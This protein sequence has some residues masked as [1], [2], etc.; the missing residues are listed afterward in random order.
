MRAT[1]DI[2]SSERDK[3]EEETLAVVNKH[4]AHLRYCGCAAATAKGLT[5]A[6]TRIDDH[7]PDV[8]LLGHRNHADECL[9]VVLLL[10]RLR[11][12]A[13]TEGRR[14]LRLLFVWLG[15]MPAD[16]SGYGL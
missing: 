12:E 10:Q 2:L 9:H 8:R 15:A 16:S 5:Y 1:A 11:R 4:A 3:I 13:A 6:H 7:L 14:L